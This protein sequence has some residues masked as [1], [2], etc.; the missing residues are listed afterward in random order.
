LKTIGTVIATYNGAKYLEEQI[1]SIFNQS[2]KPHKIIVVDDCSTDGTPGIIG[3]YRETYPGIIV[4]EQNERNLGYVRTFER[5]ISICQTDYIAISDQDDIWKPDKV[6]KCFFTLEQN[7][8]AKLCFHDL[9]FIDGSGNPLDKN[10]WESAL[11][12][13]PASGATARKRLANLVNGV[14]GCTMFFSSDLKEYLLP[15]PNSKWSGHDWWIAVVG[16]FLANPI[17]VSETLTRYRIHENQTCALAVNIKRKRKRRTFKGILFRIKRE[18]KRII[19]R[20]RI[21]RIRSEEKRER[22]R[23]LS[24]DLLKAI[25]MYEALNLNHIT[26]EELSNLKEMLKS[27][28]MI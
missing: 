6:E 24:K 1:D 7:Q 22:E 20:R 2:L 12:P 23:A 21:R 9:E 3:K 28:F 8:D 15:M 17:I 14:P 27:K 26:E 16:F 4:F 18:T 13:L 25:S 10:F 11:I 19:L 5:A